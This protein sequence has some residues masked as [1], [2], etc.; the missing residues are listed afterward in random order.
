MLDQ[1]ARGLETADAVAVIAT[2]AEDVTLRVA[3]HDQPFEGRPAAG[4]IL[5][6]VLDG[7]LHDITVVET[8]EGD[9]V[10]VLMLSAQVA[11][12]PGRA[13][14]LLVVR[15]DATGQ[16]KDLT[17]FLRPLPAL[18]ALADDMGRRLGGPLPTEDR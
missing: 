10:T 4:A 17:V 13:D 14:G 12:H 8:I 6:A 15:P 7:A 18:N 9:G 3:V 5:G 1:L 16:I 11:E 2:L